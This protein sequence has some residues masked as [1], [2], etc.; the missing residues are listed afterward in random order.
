VRTLAV[1]ADGVE[2]GGESGVIGK[3]HSAIAVAAERLGR[4]ERRAGNVTEGAG[5]FILILC[6]EGL[7]CVFNDEHLVFLSD[8]IDGVVVGGKA[9]Q[10]YRNDATGAKPYPLTLAL[11]HQGRGNRFWQRV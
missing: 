10:I 2:G 3:A 7:G 5:H 6:A 8:F 11:S 9:K 4:E 1:N